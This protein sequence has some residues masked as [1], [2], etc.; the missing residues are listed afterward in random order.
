M[1]RRGQSG[2]PI[3]QHVCA[4]VWKADLVYSMSKVLS[5]YFWGKTV[6]WKAAN[7]LPADTKPSETK[8]LF[9]PSNFMAL[10]LLADGLRAFLHVNA[11]TACAGKRGIPMEKGQA[12]EEWSARRRPRAANDDTLDDYNQGKAARKN[13]NRLRTGG[14][15]K[16]QSAGYPNRIASRFDALRKE[17]SIDC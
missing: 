6:E 16:D 13:L 10:I 4:I 11:C 8:S 12:E 15:S 3:F 5:A 14:A 17:R 1:A 7:A 2:P 9:R